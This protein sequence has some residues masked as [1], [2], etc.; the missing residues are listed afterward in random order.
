M[1]AGYVGIRIVAG[2][3][4]S[5]TGSG[6]GDGGKTFACVILIPIGLKTLT[7]NRDSH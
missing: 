6:F 2:H 4:I 3:I 1:D 5:G 7:G